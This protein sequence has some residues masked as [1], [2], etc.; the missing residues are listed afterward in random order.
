MLAQSE[1][2]HYAAAKQLLA[3]LIT[4]ANVLGWRPLEGEVLLAAA[5]LADSTGEDPDAIR[6][7]KDAAVAAEA[8]RD[9]E[10]AALARN[11]LVWVTGERLGKYDEALDLARDA[12]AKVERLGH[13]DMLRAD[14]D[15]KIA[16]VLVEQ[17]K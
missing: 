4:E 11:G 16:A 5:Q 1:A 3:P 2:G 10:T 14:L 17:G 15:Q 12:E 9:D 13:N 8:G 7:F 6:L